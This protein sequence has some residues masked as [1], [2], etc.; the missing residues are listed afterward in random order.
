MYRAIDWDVCCQIYPIPTKNH[1]PEAVVGGFIVAIILLIVDKTSG[2]TF[3]FD[4]SLQSLL[5]I[6][7]FSSIGLS[8][9]FSRLIK[10]G[11]PWYYSLLL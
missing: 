10:G 3:T 1:I 7:F 2:Y 8:S 5:M 9:D 6:A 4:S 11:K